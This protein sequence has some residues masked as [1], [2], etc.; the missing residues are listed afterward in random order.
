MEIAFKKITKDGLDFSVD[1]NKTCFSGTVCILP[2]SLI[3]CKGL[4]VG[5]I[6]HNC[7]RCGDEL[8]LNLNEKVNLLISDGV[9]KTK[10]E[11]LD[12]IEFYEGVIDFNEILNSEIES[13]KS[14][15]HYCDECIKL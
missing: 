3:S 14:D 15:Y 10:E 11:G 12:V 1:E 5:E 6:L 4:I 13:I 8:D 7:D 9:C 2:S